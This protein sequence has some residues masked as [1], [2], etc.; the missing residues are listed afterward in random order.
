MRAE[1]WWSSLPTA[2]LLLVEYLKYMAAQVRMRL[3]PSP[4]RTD[5][6]RRDGHDRS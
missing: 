3:E 6:A 2:K 1:P 5:V 4:D